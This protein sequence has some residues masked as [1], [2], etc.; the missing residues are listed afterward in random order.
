MSHRV[1]A[2]WRSIR[3]VRRYAV[4]L[5]TGFAFGACAVPAAAGPIG[6]S[7]SGGLYSDGEDDFVAGA[8]ARFGLGTISI[9]PNA[10]YIFVDRGTSY[11]LN[12]DATMNVLPLGA[13]SG[14]L[15][16]GLGIFTADPDG[17]DSNTETVVNALAGIGLNAV[18]LKPYGQVKYV[19]VDGN[20]P[21][22]F[23]VG[24]RF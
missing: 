9:V 22:V 13:A 11:S 23:S 17:A 6:W 2:A 16:A 7:V 18:P 4:L 10:E 20:D 8:G 24:V 14:W 15:G 12:V 3:L 5:L 1:I 21:F 19:F